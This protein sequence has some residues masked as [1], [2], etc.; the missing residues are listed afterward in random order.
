MTNGGE[1]DATEQS[2]DD[3]GASKA[4]RLEKE[5]KPQQQQQQQNN[6]VALASNTNENGKLLSA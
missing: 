1:G 4:I 2:Q 6:D 5:Q 3:I